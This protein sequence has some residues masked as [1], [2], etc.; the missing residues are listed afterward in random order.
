ME[1][2]RVDRFSPLLSLESIGWILVVLVLGEVVLP[3]TYPSSPLVPLS[4]TQWCMKHLATSASGR[5]DQHISLNLLIILLLQEVSDLGLTLTSL[6]ELRISCKLV[7]T[8]GS[9]ALRESMEAPHPLVRQ[10][11]MR[12]GKITQQMYPWKFEEQVGK[13]RICCMWQIMQVQI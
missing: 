8:I 3:T 12:F 6:G 9:T 4:G 13:Q 5:Q 11:K 7:V 1:L 2:G 10:P